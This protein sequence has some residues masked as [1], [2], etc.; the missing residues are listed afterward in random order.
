[1]IIL[2]LAHFFLL[3]S[4]PGDAI[5]EFMRFHFRSSS[6]SHP[7]IIDLRNMRSL[8]KRCVGQQGVRGTSN[9]YLWFFRSALELNF[10][11]SS[12]IFWYSLISSSFWK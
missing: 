4:F 1:M 2:I 7:R 9:S 10:L 11:I 12:F 6:S 3:L 5:L 8:K